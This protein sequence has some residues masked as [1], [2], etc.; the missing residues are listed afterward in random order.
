MATYIQSSE[1]EDFDLIQGIGKTNLKGI[2][3]TNAWYQIK[4]LHLSEFRRNNK[5]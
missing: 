4:E 1:K 3:K 5:L 2:I